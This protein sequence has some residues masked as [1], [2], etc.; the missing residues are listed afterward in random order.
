M[1][2]FFQVD[3]EKDGNIEERDDDDDN[4]KGI[5]N[6]NKKEMVAQ[7]TKKSPVI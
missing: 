5:D 1:K 4:Y 7:M 3:G 6:N 2:Y